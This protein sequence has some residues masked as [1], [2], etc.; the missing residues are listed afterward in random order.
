M[1]CAVAIC[2]LYVLVGRA[3]AQGRVRTIPVPN[4]GEPAAARVDAHGTIHLVFNSE[5]G[6]QYSKLIENGETLSSPIAV[7]N[8]ESLNPDLKF[9][10][11]DMAVGP[12]SEVHVALGSNAWKLKLPKEEW[13]LYYARLDAGQ[14][15]FAPLRNINHQ[16]SEGFSI[17]TDERGDVTACW[18]AGK[19]FANVS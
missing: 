17:A 18:L 16:S 4:G 13:A 7:V 15:A 19:L 2:L 8:G 14:N 6:P 9:A 11:W 3:S 1:R 12:Q 10:A 5:N